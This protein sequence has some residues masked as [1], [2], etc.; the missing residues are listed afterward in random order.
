[1]LPSHV[2]TTHCVTDHVLAPESGLRLALA[3]LGAPPA[4][5]FVTRKLSPSWVLW[6]RAW[7]QLSLTRASVMSDT[8]DVF[9]TNSETKRTLNLG[10]W[11][12]VSKYPF[13]TRPQR[14]VQSENTL[15]RSSQTRNQ[16]SKRFH[17]QKRRIKRLSS[18]KN[19]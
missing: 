9:T 3:G 12:K 7:V 4:V 10:F 18:A 11:I 17:Q 1:M 8:S 2:S 13:D 19:L 16:S 15:I 14:L 5:S 6:D